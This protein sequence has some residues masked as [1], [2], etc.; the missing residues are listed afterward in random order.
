MERGGKKGCLF[1]G[2]VNNQQS[3]Q[4]STK[5]PEVLAIFSF[6]LRGNGSMTLHPPFIYLLSAYAFE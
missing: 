3:F 2:L 1:G 6:K 5:A 4:S